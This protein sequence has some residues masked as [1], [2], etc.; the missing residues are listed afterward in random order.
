MGILDE[1]L[2]PQVKPISGI[3]I[4]SMLASG[5]SHQ[6][7][8]RNFDICAYQPA[9]EVGV[10]R[11]ALATGMVCFAA[12]AQGFANPVTTTGCAAGGVVSG[13]GYVANN[14][15]SRHCGNRFT[16]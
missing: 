3:T 16:P 10:D 7:P 1:I 15:L 8:Q 4:E 9:L 6:P 11:A 12:G 5:P 2:G 13:L 14:T